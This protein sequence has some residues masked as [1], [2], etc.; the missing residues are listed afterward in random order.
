MVAEVLASPVP[1]VSD[2]A[3]VESLQSLAPPDWPT[4][5]ALQP[6]R[7][8]NIVKPVD[9][10]QFKEAMRSLGFYWLLLNEPP[11]S[12]FVPEVSE[13]QNGRT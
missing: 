5:L 4:R 7:Q 1:D 8:R 3:A 9:F 13:Q 10:D 6:T 2:D 11:P 12:T